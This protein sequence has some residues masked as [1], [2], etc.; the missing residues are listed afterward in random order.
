MQRERKKKIIKHA[1]HTC[2]FVAL[3]YIHH[4]TYVRVQFFFFNETKTNVNG[5]AGISLLC[6]MSHRAHSSE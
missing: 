2:A 5:P 4:K 1:S 6:P 3:Y